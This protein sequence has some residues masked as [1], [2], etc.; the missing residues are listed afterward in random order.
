MSKQ[1]RNF[2]YVRINGEVIRDPFDDEEMRIL[3][4]EFAEKLNTLGLKF[5][6]GVEFGI[7]LI[8]ENDP[9]WGAE[10]ENASW[11]GDRWVGP[12][13]DIFNLGFPTL[14]IQNWKWHYF[15]LGEWS[16]KNYGKYKETHTGFEKNIYFRVN[17]QMDQICLVD[18]S[19]IRDEKKVKYVFDKKVS[20]S[21]Y[22]EDWICVPKEHVRTFN[23]QLNGEWLENG[24]YCGPTQKELSDME[25]EYARRRVNE[26]IFA[27]Q[28]NINNNV[29]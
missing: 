24:P 20:N 11:N 4:I 26:I 8:C 12:Q 22:A 13:Q 15:G 7:D 5:V 16:I 27:K 6:G 19:V 14:N 18:A 10:G 25:N 23:K 29:Q 1:K 9:T 2:R 3:F 28:N 21:D 17:A